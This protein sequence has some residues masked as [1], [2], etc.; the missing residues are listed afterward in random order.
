MTD[1]AMHR[2]GPVNP[3][4]REP[5]RD[6]SIDARDSMSAEDAEEHDRWL[7]ENVPPHH[8]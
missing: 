7:R 1:S 8:S 3:D 2:Q 4:S 6:T 5:L